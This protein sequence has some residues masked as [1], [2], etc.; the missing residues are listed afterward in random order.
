MF[1]RGVY[2]TIVGEALEPPAEFPNSCGF[3]AVRRMTDKT[4][5]PQVF[6]VALSTGVPPVAMRT[7]I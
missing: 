3:F 6:S 7:H 1:F 4:G 2:A 5:K